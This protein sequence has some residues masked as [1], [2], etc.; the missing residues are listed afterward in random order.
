L[1][2]IFVVVFQSLFPRETGVPHK[3]GLNSDKLGLSFWFR[4]SYEGVLLAV[5]SKKK[6]RISGR[7][8]AERIGVLYI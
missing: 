8:I 4:Y 6:E 3:N 5:V 2:V 1:V 7:W